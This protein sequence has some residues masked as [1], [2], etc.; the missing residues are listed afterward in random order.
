MNIR[1]IFTN[2]IGYDFLDV[3]LQEI[4]S[5]CY[6]LKKET[7]GR[8]VSN[9]GGWQSS[10]IVTT[11]DNYALIHLK[12][13]INHRVAK[14]LELL[15]FNCKFSLNGLW[16]N[17]NNKNDYNIPHTHGFCIFAG[18]FYVKTNENSG[19]I[20]LRNPNPG[21]GMCIDSSNIE[22]NNEFNSL[23]W[24]VNPEPGKMLL[25]PS[26]IDH[27]TTPNADDQDRISIAFNVGIL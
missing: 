20:I 26:W 18:V 27:Y 14:V 6:Q 4:E 25:W 12:E 24:I 2:F 13:E 3:N 9:Y 15:G 11:T 22:T 17:I 23:I 8:I 16:I 19:K 1:H 7:D 10:D 5:Y 21:H